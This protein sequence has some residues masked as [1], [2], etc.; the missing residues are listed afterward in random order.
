MST[1]MGLEVQFGDLQ[2]SL[3]SV[4]RRGDGL[5]FHVALDLA[6]LPLPSSEKASKTLSS[7]G[8]GEGVGGLFSSICRLK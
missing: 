3:D 7:G 5:D 1:P 8:R 4:I 6:A 2:Y